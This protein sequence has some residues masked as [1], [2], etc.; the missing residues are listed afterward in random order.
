MGLGPNVA[1][2][3][4]GCVQ[5]ECSLYTDKYGIWW[6]YIWMPRVQ[7]LV[8]SRVRESVANPAWISKNPRISTWISMIFWCQSSIIYTSVDIHIDIQKWIFMQGHPAMDIRKQYISINGCPFLWI[9]VFNYPYLHGYPFGYPWI[10]M[11]IH[12]LTWYGFS[13]Q[14]YP[15]SDNK[16]R[17]FLFATRH[18]CRKS[19]WLGKKDQEE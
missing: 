13:I 12:A 2:W 14:G 4:P 15:F 5:H 16:Y 18:E 8:T 9:S 17:K 6:L 1:L 3:K 7:N 11:D 19:I 10:S